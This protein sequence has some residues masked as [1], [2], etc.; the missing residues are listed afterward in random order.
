MLVK[1]GEI[2]QIKKMASEFV[3][4]KGRLLKTDGLPGGTSG[5]VLCLFGP[6]KTKKTEPNK[7]NTKPETPP[8]NP[9]YRLNFNSSVDHSDDAVR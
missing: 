7:R 8:E 9:E 2:D 6:A 3:G 1:L 5:L 4:K